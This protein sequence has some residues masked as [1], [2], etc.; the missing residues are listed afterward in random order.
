MAI[1]LEVLA[2]P[3]GAGLR[4][5]ARE[6]LIIGRRDGDAVIEDAKM[7]S[8]HARLES[9][10]GVWL[11]RDLGSSN[12]IKVGQ[13]RV[14][15]IELIVGMEFVIGSTTFVVRDADTLPDIAPGEFE[16]TG[17]IEVP[18]EALTWKEILQNLIDRAIRLSPHPTR[19]GGI[20]PLP[21]VLRLEISNGPQAGT[22]WRI[23]YWPRVV[24]AASFDF[25]L[26]DSGIP[27]T[28]FS[29][30]SSGGKILLV[31]HEPEYIKCNGEKLIRQEPLELRSGDRLDVGRVK[32][33][34]VME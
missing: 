5:P 34:V 17:S 22:I 25:P 8:R 10:N 31:P 1:L 23:G 19:D 28:C 26:L 6:G 24:G 14:E 11:I 21:R 15:S 7:S 27:D 4:I 16:F 18:A 30:E 33:R 9:R 12:K 3:G 32:F 2:G 29:I 13:Q 20:R